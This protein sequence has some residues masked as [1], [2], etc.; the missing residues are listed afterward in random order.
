MVIKK[1]YILQFIIFA[2]AICF[3][4]S[5]KKV[6]SIN[7][8]PYCF[9][10]QVE[11]EFEGCID[12]IYMYTYH[13]KAVFLVEPKDCPDARYELYDINCSFICFPYGGNLGPGIINCPN[14]FAE[15]TDGKLVYSK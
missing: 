15:A 10:K 1:T 13:G 14:F 9:Q 2:V 8:L 5:C 4:D 11:L 6:D 12:K 3:L 7:N